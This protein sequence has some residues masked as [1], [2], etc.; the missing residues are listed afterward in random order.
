MSFWQNIF[1]TKNAQIEQLIKKDAL[2]LDVRSEWE[3]KA[4]GLAK[5]KNIPI[6]QLFQRLNELKKEEPIVVFCRSGNRS[7]H[8]A[9]LLKKEGFLEVVDAQTIENIQQFL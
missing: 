8:A 2:L 3:F 9:H 6:E 5:S 1:R 4:N 7:R